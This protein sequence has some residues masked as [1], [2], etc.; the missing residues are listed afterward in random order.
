MAAPTLAVNKTLYFYPKP[1]AQQSPNQLNPIDSLA[2]KSG[3]H[4]TDYAFAPSWLRPK[5]LKLDYEQFYFLVKSQTTHFYE[6]EVN[7]QTN[8]K[9]WVAKK[10]LNFR[11]WTQFL[12]D[13][14]SVEPTSTKN[15]IR[16][17]ADDNASIVLAFDRSI[18]FLKVIASEGDWIQVEILDT[19]YK[20]IGTG[21]LKWRIDK[22]LAVS[23]SL[24]S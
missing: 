11:N 7:A 18:H 12:K 20:K 9:S 23:Y 14:H 1:T 2:F 8:K 3:P 15:V 19:Q 13:M 16:E 21:W 4:G 22:E 17:N 10:D 24:L 6:V 5:I